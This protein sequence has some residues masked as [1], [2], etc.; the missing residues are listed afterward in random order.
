MSEFPQLTPSPRARGKYTVRAPYILSA[1]RDY[2]CIAIR[3]FAD[4]Y[5]EKL[6]PYKLVYES[7]GLV[8]GVTQSNGIVFRYGEESARGINIITLSDD[9]GV[10]YLI[11]D[12]YLTG[13]P[14]STGI[15]YLEFVLSVSLGPL[16]STMDLSVAVNAVSEAVS[17]QF[18]IT[19][20]I[21]THSLPTTTNPTYE[22]HL[23]VEAARQG[24]MVYGSNKDNTIKQL[25]ASLAAK[26]ATIVTLMAILS[27][28]NLL[29]T[30]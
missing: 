2:T 24:R 23:A 30:G 26:D 19:P 29:P 25:N 27:E 6:D 15:Q 14:T 7:V 5:R 22:E 16:P 12:N 9:L 18:G 20:V 4:M 10:H 28:N 13:I 8:D 21:K 3:S 1:D 17:S 11:P